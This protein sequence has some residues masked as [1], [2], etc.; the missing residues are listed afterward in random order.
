MILRSCNDLVTP[1][2]PKN[3]LVYSQLLL[4]N[5][6]EDVYLLVTNFS[7]VRRRRTLEGEKSPPNPSSLK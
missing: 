4:R 7:R 1:H 2:K 5:C 6:V 3:F